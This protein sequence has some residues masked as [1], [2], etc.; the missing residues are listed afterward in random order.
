[1]TFALFVGS[2]G[3]ECQYGFMDSSKTSITRKQCN[4]LECFAVPCVVGNAPIS[5]RVM[6]WGCLD[7]K[8]AQACNDHVAGETQVSKLIREEFFPSQSNLQFHCLE[9]KLGKF[10]KTM[11]NT[12]FRDADVDR[13]WKYRLGSPVGGSTCNSVA[14]PLMLLAFLASVRAVFGQ[15]FGGNF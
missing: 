15:T 5:P 4:A 8:K 6:V 11:D 9:C 1:M 3:I 12:H 14:L 2:A 13:V 10:G 7:S